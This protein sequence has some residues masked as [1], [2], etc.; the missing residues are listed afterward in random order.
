LQKSL[1]T[2]PTGFFKQHAG[3]YHIGP[4]KGARIENRAVH[5]GLSRS[6]DYS[7]N[8]MLTNETLDQRLIT[9][10]AVNESIP[11]V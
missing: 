6:I 7:L 4:R 9:D 11:R 10:V 8:P 3:P 2:G 1:Q 5:M